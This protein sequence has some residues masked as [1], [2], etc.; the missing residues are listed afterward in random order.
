MGAVRNDEHAAATLPTPAKFLI[1]ND[2]L[3]PVEHIVEI[4]ISALN[5]HKTVVVVTTTGHLQV[6]DDAAVKLLRIYGVV[7]EE[8]APPA[9]AKKGGKG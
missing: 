7:V 8:A 6:H 5:S 4:D 3:V 2:H 1:I 9:P